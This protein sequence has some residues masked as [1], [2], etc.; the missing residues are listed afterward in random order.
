MRRIQYINNSW[1]LDKYLSYLDRIEPNI[2]E[3]IRS[4][5]TD[6]NRYIPNT[7]LT[8]HDAW[9]IRQ[10]YEIKIITEE[11]ELDFLSSDQKRTF[12]FKFE[13]VC[14]LDFNVKLYKKN[15]LI[16]HEFSIIEPNLFQYLFYFQD[17]STI[18]IKFKKLQIVENILVK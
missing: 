10:S 12:S 2:P 14:K 7:S 6:V 16:F 11:V 13:S 15:D 5:I 18:K 9:L 8:L 3:I 1:N 17:K 4:F